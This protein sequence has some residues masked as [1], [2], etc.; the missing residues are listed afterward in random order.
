MYE[1]SVPYKKIF[2]LKF[3]FRY[4]KR[5]TTLIHFESSSNDMVIHI[6]INPF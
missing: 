4:T 6:L 5:Q 2:K 1:G 3:I